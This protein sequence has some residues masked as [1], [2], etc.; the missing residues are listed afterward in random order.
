M[1]HLAHKNEPCGISLFF[2]SGSIMF[3]DNANFWEN[4]MPAGIKRGEEQEVEEIWELKG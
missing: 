3:I 4:V 1:S 2:I